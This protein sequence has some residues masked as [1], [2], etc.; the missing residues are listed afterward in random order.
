MEGLS[1][2]SPDLSCFLLSPVSEDGSYQPQ[3]DK[4]S[5]T[6]THYNRIHGWARRRID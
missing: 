3:K 4:V 5:D 1:I 2:W 6:T